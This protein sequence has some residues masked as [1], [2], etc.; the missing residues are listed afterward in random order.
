MPPSDC[1]K[2]LNC[3]RTLGSLGLTFGPIL[4][5]YLYELKDGFFNVC[6]VTSIVFIINTALMFVIR[7]PEKGQ[8]RQND[9]IWSDLSKIAKIDWRVFWDVFLL[10]FICNFGVTMYYFPQCLYLKE[11][12][13]VSQRYIGYTISIFSATR[14]VSSFLTPYINNYFYKNDEFCL[15]RMTHFLLLI[16]TSSVPLYK[17]SNIE[18]FWLYTIPFSMGCTLVNTSINRI[19]GEESWGST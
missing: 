6:L 11:K 19:N 16:T 18:M 8:N 9:P 2:A 5:G 15:K 4:A 7:K 12:F 10:R 3:L 13:E 17:S 1:A 14:I